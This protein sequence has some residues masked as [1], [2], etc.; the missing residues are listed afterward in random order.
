MF[1]KGRTLAQRVNAS[2]KRQALERGFSFHIG[3]RERRILVNLDH[4]G[5]HVGV[6][7]GS[8]EVRIARATQAAVAVEVGDDPRGMLHGLLVVVTTILSN[9]VGKFGVGTERVLRDVGFD[10]VARIGRE[11]VIHIAKLTLTLQDTI[12][13]KAAWNTRRVFLH[14]DSTT[15]SSGQM[16]IEVLRPVNDTISDDGGTHVSLLGVVDFLD[17]GKTI[18]VGGTFEFAGVPQRN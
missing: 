1:A 14:V 17:V 12:L 10:R 15:A 8:Q 6:F 2:R 11:T 9:L 13:V 7:D 5:S 16:T 3:W 18:F 4:R